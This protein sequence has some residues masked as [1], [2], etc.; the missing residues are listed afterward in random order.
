MTNINVDI[1]QADA[2]AHVTVMRPKVLNA[3]NAATINE[4]HDAFH[5]LQD[6]AVVRAVVLT[7]SET[8]PARSR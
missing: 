8:S 1:E 3:L 7:G 6:D 2:V 4:L 5:A